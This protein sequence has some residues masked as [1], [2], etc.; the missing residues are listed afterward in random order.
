MPVHRMGKDIEEAAGR[1]RA[2]E[3]VGMPTETVYGLAADATQEAAVAA[4]FEAKGRPRFDPLILH[5]PSTAE[6]SKWASAFPAP[7]RRLAERFW[8]GPL[9]LLLP[10]GPGIPDLVT[11]GLPR[12]AFRVPDHPMTLALLERV[13]RPLAAPSANPFGYVSPTTASHVARQLGTKVSYILDGGACGVGLESTIVGLDET[14][15]PTVYRLGGLSVEALEA[16][17]GRMKQALNRSSNPQAPGQ[18]KR[19]YAPAKAFRLG[20]TAALEEL[21]YQRVALLRFARRAPEHPRIVHQEVLSPSGDTH[22]AAR[23]LF[24]ALRRLD[25]M[26]V[27]LV[28]AEPAPEQGLGPAIND[29]L[30]RAAAEA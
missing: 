11:A 2:G 19:H 26:D 1:L 24:A 29:R 30:R 16:T 7:L 5:L 8:P 21:P 10:R 6:A 14:G 18:L 9:T 25:A 3:L 15:A 23:R 13:A 12:A 28:L 27:D 4:I 20:E 17:A 22:E